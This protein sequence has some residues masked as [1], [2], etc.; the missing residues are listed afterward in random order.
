MLARI[1]A[2][3]EQF[4]PNVLLRP[5]VQDYLLPT[6]AYAG[7]AAE[8][9]YF[10]QAGAVYEVLLGRVT[11]IVPRFSATIVEP[12][13]QRLLE[14]HGITLREV[15]NGPESL[16]QELAARNLPGELQAAFDVANKS[17]ESNLITIREKLEK[18]DR[19]LVEAAQTASSKMRYQL[20]RLYTQAAR[21]ELQK[22]EVV[23]RHAETLTQSLFPGKGL[24]E[25]EIGG[26]YFLA[27]Y[28]LDLLRQLHDTIQLDCHDHQILEL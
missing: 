7:G 25:R 9:A 5:V 16:R 2:T 14:R 22:G 23:G 3:P 8:A 19:T 17:L 6:L 26:A 21:A 13:T 1:A 12:K 11:P 27:R 20:D 10:S 18:L 28:G 15:L 24:Q 4:S